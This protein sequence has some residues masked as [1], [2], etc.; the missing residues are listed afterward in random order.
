VQVRTGAEPAAV[1]DETAAGGG[2]QH[3][4]VGFRTVRRSRL[5]PI[6]QALRA[7]PSG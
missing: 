5:E 3:I 2:A 6:A 4:I 7:V 1:A